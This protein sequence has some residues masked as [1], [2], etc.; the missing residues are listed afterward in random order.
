MHLFVRTLIKTANTLTIE[1]EPEYTIL[2]V[3]QIIEEE[4]GILVDNQRL[5]FSGVVLLNDRTLESY[6]I[7]RESCL[8][9]VTEVKQ[10]PTIDLTQLKTSILE[11]TNSL[12]VQGNNATRIIRQ[13]DEKKL[14]SLAS[15]Q[16]V[17]EF[18]KANI[19]PPAIFEFSH[20]IHEQV[21][22]KNTLTNLET[23]IK[24][25]EKELDDLNRELEIL[26]KKIQQKKIE[27][28]SKIN[29]IEEI[30]EIFDKSIQIQDNF[31]APFITVAQEKFKTKYC[32]SKNELETIKG[33]DIITFWS[34]TGLPFPQ[35]LKSDVNQ[36]SF[37]NLSEV[38]LENDFEVSSL[39]QRKLLLADLDFLQDGAFFI[40]NTSHK[41]SCSTCQLDT[42]QKLVYALENIPSCKKYDKTILDLGLTGLSFIYLTN[43]DLA[44]KLKL[45][46]ADRKAFL[47]IITTLSAPHTNLVPKGNYF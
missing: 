4:N 46:A 2:R 39:H 6:S 7:H 21:G 34:F 23:E 29:K 3:K 26:Q 41:N 44:A 43:A 8:H 40:K 32:N 42:P 45:P 17:S 37:E 1:V 12:S 38:D 13:L 30:K 24:T 19:L 33:Q 28:Q 35:N 9:L 27:I 16:N 25:G 47:S 18:L 10:A 14:S 15:T 22:A 11:I 5:I 31:L 20:L 36:L